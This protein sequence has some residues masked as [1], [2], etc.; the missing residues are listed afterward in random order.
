MWRRTDPYRFWILA[1]L[2][3]ALRVP[4]VLAQSYGT[5]DQVLTIGMGESPATF[6]YLDSNGYVS[7][8]RFNQGSNVFHLPVPLPDGAEVEQMC[9]Y[10]NDLQG[11]DP[12]T[13]SLI[14]VKLVPGGGGDPITVTIPNS[15]VQTTTGAGYAV[16]CAAS[17]SY[18]LR[19]FVDLDG[20]QVPDHAA[21]YLRISLGYHAAIGGVLVTWRR[22]V[23]P[24]PDSPTFDDVPANDGA[25]A[26]IEALAASGV[27]AGCGGPNYCPNAPLTR[28]QMAVYLAKALGLH[29]AN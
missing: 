14:A 20:D 21:Y 24:A 25:F 15:T 13:V 8:T 1:L 29:W 19:N 4:S 7:D 2:A 18:T 11:Y 6:N 28:R 26:Q 27:T 22:Q 17:I 23:S 10:A 5:N 16:Y 9:V 3:V 12:T